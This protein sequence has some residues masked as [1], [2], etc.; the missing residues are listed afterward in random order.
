MVQ[1][2]IPSSGKNRRG[3]GF[4]P[5]RAPDEVATRFLDV[6]TALRHVGIRVGH[7]EYDEVAVLSFVPRAADKVAPMVAHHRGRLDA[8]LSWLTG[9]MAT[10]LAANLGFLRLLFG[11]GDVAALADAKLLLDMQSI[12]AARQAAAVAAVAASS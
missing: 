9:P 8:E 10:S 11:D 7:A 4:V 3:P 6:A 12:V 2:T 1:I 5:P